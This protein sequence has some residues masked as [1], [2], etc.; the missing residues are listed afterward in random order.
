MIAGEIGLAGHGGGC[1]LRVKVRPGAR[2]EAILGPHGGALRIS[3]IAPPERGK[4]NRAVAALLARRLGL[5][6]SRIQIVSG[7]TAPGKT[8][9]VEGLSAR[10]VLSRL[11]T[12]PA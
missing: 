6:V 5:P 2:E 10:E 12:D 7:L 8:I 1:R 3:V 9:Q 4:A 11:E